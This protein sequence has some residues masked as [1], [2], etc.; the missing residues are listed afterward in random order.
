M[1]APSS[2]IQKIPDDFKEP[3]VPQLPSEN[4][5]SCQV[6]YGI[7]KLFLPLH[8][9]TFNKG[10]KET[11]TGVGWGAGKGCS[12]S[13]GNRSVEAVSPSLGKITGCEAAGC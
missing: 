6:P 12:S 10:L 2:V 3:I 4:H 1:W 7:Q 13:V 9:R 5:S 11:V 8:K